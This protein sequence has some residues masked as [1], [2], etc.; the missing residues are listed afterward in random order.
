MARKVKKKEDIE[1][2]RHEAETRKNAVPVGMA[3]YDTSRPKPKKYDYDPHLD[4]QL[5]W[6]GK[7]EHTSFEVSAV[8][9][10]IH[11]RIAPE[12]II[13]LIKREDPQ[14]DLFAKPE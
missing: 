11:E 12:A 1:A 6:S 5:V 13:R 8:S 14:I 2:Y 3:S 10:H 9:L 4:P 7:K